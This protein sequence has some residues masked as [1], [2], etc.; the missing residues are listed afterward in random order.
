M[1]KW[2][3]KDGNEP[4]RRQICKSEVNMRMFNGHSTR[5]VLSAG[6]KVMTIISEK[7][8]QYAMRQ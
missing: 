7:R 3:S 4:A 1:R 2:V 5:E 6:E 8:E